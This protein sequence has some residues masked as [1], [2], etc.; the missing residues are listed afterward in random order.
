MEA[1]ARD[2]T[3]WQLNRIRI[4]LNNYRIATTRD[5]YM[6]SWTTVRDTIIYAEPNIARYRRDPD[7]S[8]HPERLRRFANGDQRLDV[9]KIAEILRFLLHGGYIKESDLDESQANLSPFLAMRDFLGNASEAA[10][11]SV[12]AL[13]SEYATISRTSNEKTKSF[14]LRLMPD[15]SHTF[16]RVEEIARIAAPPDDRPA[17]YHRDD[18][19]RLN[20]KRTGYGLPVTARNLL[21]IF[22]VSYTPEQHLT[23][24]QVPETAQ[25]PAGGIVL[26]RNGDDPAAPQNMAQPIPVGELASPNIYRFTVGAKARVKRAAKSKTAAKNLKWVILPR[27]SRDVSISYDE[28]EEELLAQVIPSMPDAVR[29]GNVSNLY[30]PLRLGRDI[31][32]RDANG[33]TALH[34]AAAMG[35]RACV[36]FLAS[37]RDCDFL[38]RDHAGRTAAELAFVWSADRASAAFLAK[39]QARQAHSRGL[40]NGVP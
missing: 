11:A 5:S 17:Q 13:E 9:G 4:A 20:M 39:K 26:M 14:V 7:N 19:V 31:N 27:I 25:S 33:M 8:F 18:D 29:S 24:V 23:Y 15:P 3:E 30:L 40:V 21:H 1:K 10:L 35:A 37:H 6:P 36:R 28:Y 38:I 2:Y 32:E 22:L 34:H 12:A 16:V